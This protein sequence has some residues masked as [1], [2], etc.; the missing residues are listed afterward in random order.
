[1]RTKTEMLNDLKSRIYYSNTV[2]MLSDGRVKKIDDVKLPLSIFHKFFLFF[3]KPEITQLTTQTIKAHLI[4]RNAHV[5]DFVNSIIDTFIAIFI[6]NAKEIYQDKY[7]RELL[8]IEQKHQKFVKKTLLEILGYEEQDSNFKKFF[9][10]F[11]NG[12][13]HYKLLTQLLKAELVPLYRRRLAAKIHNPAKVKEELL[14]L[15][16]NLRSHAYTQRKLSKQYKHLLE[17]PLAVSTVSTCLSDQKLKIF[18][19]SKYDLSQFIF[20]SGN[21]NY[22]NKLTGKVRSDGVAYPY[23]NS[24]FIHV[25]ENAINIATTPTLLEFYNSETSQFYTTKNPFAI[26]TEEISDYSGTMLRENNKFS[27]EHEKAMRIFKKIVE[28][29]IY[30]RNRGKFH[31]DMQTSKQIII[32]GPGFLNENE[33]KT[34]ETIREIIENTISKNEPQLRRGRRII[35]SDN[36]L[37]VGEKFPVSDPVTG[38]ETSYT[39]EKILIIT[40]MINRKFKHEVI[41][42]AGAMPK[43]AKAWSDKDIAVQYMMILSDF[44]AEYDKLKFYP[45]E[46]RIEEMRGNLFRAIVAR[47][48]GFLNTTNKDHWTYELRQFYVAYSNLIA[49]VSLPTDNTS[50][51]PPSSFS[52][53]TSQKQDTSVPQ[54]KSFSLL[55]YLQGRQD[56]SQQPLNQ[57]KFH[58]AHIKQ[59]GNTHNINVYNP[60]AETSLCAPEQ[61][62]E[63]TCNV[64]IE[65]KPDMLDGTP[66]YSSKANRFF[67]VDLESQIVLSSQCTIEQANA[68]LEHLKSILPSTE[69][70]KWKNDTFTELSEMP[71]TAV[72]A[73]LTTFV[74]QLAHD[75]ALYR[76]YS[77]EMAEIAAK[78]VYYTLIT[79]PLVYKVY[80]DVNALMSIIPMVVSMLVSKIVYDY[81][82]KFSD[83]KEHRATVSQCAYW[84]THGGI[85]AIFY[86]WLSGIF[87][88]TTAF[89]SSLSGG[90]IGNKAAHLAANHYLI[91]AFDI[92]LEKLNEKIL[93][94][95]DKLIELEY[96]ELYKAFEKNISDFYNDVA[97]TGKQDFKIYLMACKIEEYITKCNTALEKKP[98]PSRA[99]SMRR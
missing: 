8:Q 51:R 47:I 72:I 93:S 75:I 24:I 41:L 99:A 85:S 38:Y 34:W 9:S 11:V 23:Y 56:A 39:I 44:F 10:A 64:N 97:K 27:G 89:V 13:P 61:L 37:S 78:S 96:Q 35:V 2:V 82:P 81:Y 71:Q 33:K 79:A 94:L 5:A 29:L 18:M 67:G 14:S 74:T 48:P 91:G 57:T 60:A 98:Q 42:T 1:M 32:N 62:R 84:T 12:R 59:G 55:E 17:N 77:P 52:W 26:L 43:E 4:A 31:D 49:K 63:N 46:E 73:A 65:L 50:M 6:N 83:A 90:F 20:H 68:A 21:K 66:T 15:Q 54:K 86:G 45:T 25:E 22:V 92:R 19:I 36:Q 7:N 30:F 80:Q 3:R 87:K 28:N 88:A 95:H 76:G 53:K 58:I 40:K 16:A 69:Y 70:E